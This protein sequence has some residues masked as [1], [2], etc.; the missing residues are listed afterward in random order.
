MS[1]NDKQPLKC[2]PGPREE[3][4]TG[5]RMFIHD[6]GWRVMIKRGGEREFCHMMLPGQDYYHRLLDGELLVQHDNERLCA[7]CAAR[8]GIIGFEA[9]RLPDEPPKLLAESEGTAVFLLRVDDEE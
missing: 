2:E 3:V 1:I 7:A 6:P 5:S 4:A 8:R 9:R